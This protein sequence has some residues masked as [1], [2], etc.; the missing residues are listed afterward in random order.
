MPPRVIDNVAA[1]APVA[2]VLAVPDSVAV[3]PTV[4]DSVPADVVAALPVSAFDRAA[5]NAPVTV[6]IWLP[7]MARD[8]SGDREPTDA[9]LAVPERDAVAPVDGETEPTADVAETPEIEAEILGA[10]F[11][12]DVVPAVPVKDADASPPAESG[13]QTNNSSGRSNLLQTAE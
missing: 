4:G 9:V 12:A 2:V 8:T 11:P 1:S 3:A 5:D 10:A 6:E 13:I 7:A